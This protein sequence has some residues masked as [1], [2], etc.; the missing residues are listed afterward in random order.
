MST[1]GGILLRGMRWRL[2]A[3]LLTVLT[4]TVAVGVAVLGPL[5]LRTAGDSVLHTTVNAAAVS[6]RGASLIAQIGGSATLPQVQRAERTVENSGGPHRFYGQPITTVLSGVRVVGPGRS[7]YSSQL[8]WRS[9]I[10]GVLRFR[11]GGCDL[12]PG[13]VL[14]SDRSAALLHLTTGATIAAGV[15][16]SRVPLRLKVAGVYLAPNV[17]LP[18]WWGQGAGYFAYGHASGP[19]GT[20]LLDS[21]ISSAATA[22]AVPHADL[23]V[24]IGQVPLRP[25][26]VTLSNEP[27]L[28]G[29]L[30]AATASV[31]RQQLVLRTPLPA[32]LSNA[33]HQRHVMSTIVAVAA[34]QLVLLAI[35]VLAS[36]LVRTADARRSEIRVARLRGFPARTVFAVAAAEPAM[37]CLIGVPFGVG[38]AWL[39]VVVARGQLLNP[40]AAVAPDIWVFAALAATVLA[41]VA[42]L[43]VGTFRLL[44][45]SGLSEARK[46]AEGL[47]RQSALIAD[48]LMLGLSV[49]ALIALATSGAL[50]G[51]SDPIASAAP[52]LI[53]LGGAVIAVQLVLFG[54]RLGIS[55]T[56]GSRR[57]AGMLAMRQIVRRPAVLRQ[58]RVLIIALC[59]ACFASSAWSV[60]RTNRATVARFGVGTTNVVTVTPRGAELLHAVDRVD[61]TGRFAMAAVTVSTQSS[62]LLAVDSSRLG[63][64]VSWPTGVLSSGGPALA[65]RLNPRAAPEV[66]LPGA[67]VEFVAD[68][69]AA[70]ASVGRLA[71]ALWVS[72]PQGG[73][74]IVELGALRPGSFAYRGS[75][76]LV[77]PGGCRLA[78]VGVVPVGGGRTPA[79]ALHITRVLV[80]SNGSG[81]TPIAADLSPAQWHSTAAGVRISSAASGGLGLVITASAAASY[82]GA[83]GPSNPPMASVADAPSQIPGIATGV[84]ESIN[85]ASLTGGSVPN[86]GLDGNTVNITPVATASAIPRLGSDAVLVDLHVLQRAQVN[87]TISGASDEVWLGPAAPPD[88]ITRLQQA[89][90]QIDQVQRASAVFSGLQ[91]SGPALADDFLLLAT[92]AALLAAAASTLGALGATIRQRATELTALEVSGVSRLLLVRSL[93]IETGVMVLTALFGAVAGVVAAAMAIPSLPVLASP[94]LVPLRYGLPIGLLVVVSLAAIVIVVAASAGVS[95]VLLRRM[96]PVLLRTAPNDTAG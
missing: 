6:D 16:G 5:Y 39:A 13:Q 82:A 42:A 18:Y 47:S 52:G 44:R 92:I 1:R 69:A 76:A 87:P 61:P 48:A 32:I 90:L 72:N 10:C 81:W 94:S 2:G 75:L 25:S 33:S 64:V 46:P 45:A 60:A 4:A 96:S 78:G 50:A 93:A 67:P 68:T 43:G 86:Q 21:L 89:G 3:S 29:A 40:A 22:L 79:V 9:G 30:A 15:I 63:A 31:G 55:A 56:A 53:A 36:L 66:R 84:L 17:S 35:W 57:V 49:V 74:A 41:I 20:P 14:L 11:S 85:G 27:A 65:R 26:A 23:P 54:C 77:C 38:L 8:L 80:H 28:R 37:L 7:P 70:R 62:A 88:A 95:V 24:V 51:H 34:I 12:G 58:A 91:R 59:L 73:T 83:T 19:R 71:L